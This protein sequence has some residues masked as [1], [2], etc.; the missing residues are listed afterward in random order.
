MIIQDLRDINGLIENL[1]EGY[2]RRVRFQCLFALEVSINSKLLST[3][4][5]ALARP[6]NTS[7][8]SYLSPSPSPSLSLRLL[9]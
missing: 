8:A 2:R 6:V 3:L 9:N 4:Y 1:Q 5:A 7:A